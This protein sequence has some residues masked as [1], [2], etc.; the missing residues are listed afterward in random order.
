MK[1]ELKKR[2]SPDVID[3]NLFFKNGENKQKQ[4]LFNAKSKNSKKLDFERFLERLIR[5]KKALEK[6]IRRDNKDK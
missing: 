4:F 6:K 5:M 2:W 3:V 1:E